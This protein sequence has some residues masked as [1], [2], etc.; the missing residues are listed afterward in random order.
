MEEKPFFFVKKYF[1]TV[2]NDQKNLFM[3]L[4][5]LFHKLYHFV[6]FVREKIR[7]FIVFFLISHTFVQFV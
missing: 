3:T 7:D 1:K 5:A 6:T 2:T 4:L